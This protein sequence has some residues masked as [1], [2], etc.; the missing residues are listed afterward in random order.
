ME[1]NFIIH[2]KGGNL[3]LSAAEIIQN[4]QEQEKAGLKPCCKHFALDIL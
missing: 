2:R 3:I 4:A 1:R